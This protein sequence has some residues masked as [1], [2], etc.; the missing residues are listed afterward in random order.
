L[1]WH[2]A[3]TARNGSYVK[4]MARTLARHPWFSDYMYSSPGRLHAYL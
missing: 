4:A 2:V 3:A 1:H